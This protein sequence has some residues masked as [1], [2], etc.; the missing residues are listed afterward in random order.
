MD[1]SFTKNLDH[2]NILNKIICLNDILCV[3]F[4]VEIQ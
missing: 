1:F 4:Q 2:L 3:I